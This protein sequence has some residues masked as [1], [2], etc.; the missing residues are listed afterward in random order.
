[1]VGAPTLRTGTI[2]FTVDSL[3]PGEVAARLGERDICVWSGHAYA[4]ELTRALGIRDT[5]G[6]IRVSLSPYTD[7]TDLERLATAM[8]SI[9]SEPVP[10]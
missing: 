3:S 2:C 4:W 9:V 7:E 1:M 8:T 10:D 6:A 5:G